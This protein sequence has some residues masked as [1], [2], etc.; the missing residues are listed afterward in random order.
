[1]ASSVE[2]FEIHVDEEV[3]DDL[4]RRLAA[5]RFPDQIE[6]TGWEYGIPTSYVR[7]LVEYWRES[8]DWRAQEA[9]LNQLDHFRSSI[10]GQS[11]HF[12]HAR[13]PFTSTCRSLFPPM[14]LPRIPGTAVTP[15]DLGPRGSGLLDSPPIATPAGVDTALPGVSTGTLSVAV[16]RRP[17]DCRGRSNVGAADIEEDLPYT[18]PTGR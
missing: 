2:R 15:P 16:A 7:D 5:T 14:T 17:E 9:R 4:R 18:S 12:V 10:D 11:I 8:Y 13:S 3:L 6:G 1:M